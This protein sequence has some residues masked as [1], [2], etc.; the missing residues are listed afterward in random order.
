MARNK[1]SSLLSIGLTYSFNN[2]CGRPI[3]IDEGPF[4][5][6]TAQKDITAQKNFPEGIV[7]AVPVF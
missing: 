3:I 5:K 6:N 1:P 7:L 4:L 2:I